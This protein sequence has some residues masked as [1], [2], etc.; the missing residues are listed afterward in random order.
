[1]PDRLWNTEDLYNVF[2]EEDTLTLELFRHRSSALLVS[3]R[4]RDSG[5]GYVRD[6]NGS[7]AEMP[8]DGLADRSSRKNEPF[9]VLPHL[10]YACMVKP[11]PHS[12]REREIGRPEKVDRC[13]PSTV[14]RPRSLG[15]VLTDVAI[16]NTTIAMPTVMLKLPTDTATRLDRV[17]AR[18][19]TTKSAVIREA[20]ED[21]LRSFADESSVYDLMKAS[22]G[23]ID[24]GTRDLGHNP[25]HLKGF[26]LK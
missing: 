9:S 5:S 13:L 18:R 25:K 11:S 24:S 2:K 8:C 14:H 6:Q 12:D 4:D 17:A 21:K 3:A 19:R 10:F 16:G 26:G 15:V 22:V 23:S 20:L 7:D 1:L